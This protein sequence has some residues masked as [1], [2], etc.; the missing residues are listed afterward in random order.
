MWKSLLVFVFLLLTIWTTHQRSPFCTPFPA[1][2]ATTQNTFPSAAL[3]DFKSLAREAGL[4]GGQ[5][6]GWHHGVITRTIDA[7]RSGGGPALRGDG[8]EQRRTKR[9]FLADRRKCDYLHPP[10][11]SLP[12]PGYTEVKARRSQ[13][14]TDACAGRQMRCDGPQM[15]FVNT[16]EAMRRHFPCEGGCGHQVGLEL[17]C[18]VPDEKQATYRQCLT[19]DDAPNNC[20][21]S[22]AS[23]Q[24]LCP[25]VA[26]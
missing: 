21:A 3:Q 14:C 13:S 2:P 15:P 18:Y 26:R 10:H 20:G 7:P 25:C 9:L 16:C 1:L 24:R 4:W 23:T 8:K 5:P 17:P 6:R 19:S 12:S 11:L 22:H